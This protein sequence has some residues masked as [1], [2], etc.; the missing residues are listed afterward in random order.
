MSQ[1][2]GIY[3][4]SKESAVKIVSAIKGAEEFSVQ[5]HKG[6]IIA[7]SHA[8]LRAEQKERNQVKLETAMENMDVKK[9]RTVRRAVDWKNFNWLSVMPIARHQFDL[10]A[11][12]FHD[13]LAIR[14]S[15]PLLRMPA[16]CDGC[17]AL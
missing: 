7:E 15:Q 13:A 10:S 14:Y 17:G 2:C 1:R 5:E 12:E 8:R 4:S 9:Q 6:A 11:A 3:H 16:N